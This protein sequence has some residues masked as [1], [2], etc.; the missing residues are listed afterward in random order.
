[1]RFHNDGAID[2]SFATLVNPLI[3]TQIQFFQDGYMFKGMHPAAFHFDGSHQPVFFSFP[4]LSL[5]YKPQAPPMPTATSY[6]IMEDDKV[7][8]AGR[9]NP[10]TNNLEDRRLLVRVHPDGSPDTSFEPLKCEGPLDA[11]IVDFYPTHDGKWMITG[12]FNL[13]QGFES[14]GIARLHADFTVDTTFNSPFPDHTWSVRILKG[15]HPTG[16]SGAIDAQNRV[17]ILRIEPGMAP[18]SSRIKHIRLLSDGSIDSTFQINDLLRYS[19]SYNLTKGIVYVMDFEE[20]GT[21][22]VGGDFRKIAG[23]NRGG[24]AK[25]NDDGSLIENVFHRQ[26]ADTAIWTNG[27]Y[28]LPTITTF[29][30]LD[31]GRLMVGGLFSR[32]D[33]HDQWGVVRLVPSPVGVEERVGMEIKVFPNPASHYLNLEISQEFTGKTGSIALYDLSGKL[34][35]ETQTALMEHSQIPVHQLTKGIYL[36]HVT[37]GEAKAVKRF[38]KH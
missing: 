27:T 8:V 29:A 23:H 10:D 14:P 37:T 17:Y 35:H 21:L 13:V 6:Q 24:I 20:D 34:V 5:P 15:S 22:I 31:D 11:R 33:G 16:I 4:Y 26:G 12:S 18:L 30:R 36:L 7:V 38:L 19:L 2:E 3:S 32:Y 25:L 28:N 1:M 9:F